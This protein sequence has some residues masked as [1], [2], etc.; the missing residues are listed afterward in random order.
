MAKNKLTAVQVKNAPAGK[1]FDGG[2][3]TLVKSAD[4]GKWVYRYSH[5]GKRREMGLGSWPSLSLAEARKSRDTWETVLAGG[6][7][8]IEIRDAERTAEAAERDKK[9]PTLSEAVTSVFE[10]RKAKLRG[11]GKRGRWR[12]PLDLHVLPRIGRKRLSELH[13]TDIKDALMPIWRSKHPTAIK[14]AERLRIVLSECQILEYDCDPIIIDKAKRMLGD[15]RHI[16]TPIV[17]T[18]WEE[19]P[20]LYQRLNSETSSHQCLRMAMLTVVRADAVTGMRFDEVQ[21]D[22]WT[23][24]A[25]RVK[26]TEETAKEFRV[27]LSTAAIEIIESARDF[28]G[29]NG[30][31]FPGDRGT[32]ISTNAIEK[33][34]NVLKEPGRPHGLRTSFRTW[35]QDT[36]ACGYDVAETILGHVV[37]GKVER[38][39]ARS[40]M[41]DRRRPVMQAWSDYV[42]KA[43]KNV[44]QMHSIHA[45]GA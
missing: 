26:G 1:I 7:D 8:P 42:T 4:G 37:G 41:L 16:S 35:V 11:D 22:V 15:V 21:G 20:D 34:L 6:R 5:L 45:Q 24:P 28:F 18:P 13:Q 2:G 29:G 23:V 10:A 14:A 3:L 27:P 39:Y 44:I 12:S 38:A 33:A 32:P 40:D 9:D 17:S 36:D 43:A 30:P 25:D 31:V 19:I